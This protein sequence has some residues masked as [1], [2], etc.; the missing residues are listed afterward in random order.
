[1]IFAGSHIYER[2]SDC[3]SVVRINKPIFGSMHLCLSEEEKKLPR[4]KYPPLTEK[5]ITRL[6][7]A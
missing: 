7:N 3:G 6:P 1:M 4:Q 5:E 2:C